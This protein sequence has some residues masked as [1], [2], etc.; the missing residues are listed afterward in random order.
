MSFGRHQCPIISSGSTSHAGKG[1]INTYLCIKD[2]SGAIVPI[3][4]TI[5]SQIASI[6]GY[7]DEGTSSDGNRTEF[8]RLREEDALVWIQL[9]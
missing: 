7:F 2:G 3:D 5:A 6:E 1:K 9:E 8:E 4:T